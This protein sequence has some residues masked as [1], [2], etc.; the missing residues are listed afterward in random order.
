MQQQYLRNSGKK[1]PCLEHEGKN[2]IK[3]QCPNFER[4]HNLYCFPAKM[5]KGKERDAQIQALKRVNPNRRKWTPKRSDRNCSLHF[6]DG[7]PAKANPLPTMHM[8]YDTKRQKTRR[9]L[10]KHPLP[11]KREVK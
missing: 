3:G 10:F 5:T 4:L 11:A 7:I 9:P 1:E 2:V 8:G 6:V